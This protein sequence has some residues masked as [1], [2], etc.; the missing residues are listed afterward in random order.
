MTTLGQVIAR[1]DEIKPN[2]FTYEAKTVWLNECEGMIQTEIML[3]GVEEVI[4]YS[5]P[6]DEYTELLAAPPHDKVYWTYLAAM[7]DF[8]N[9]EYNRYQ[10]TV[11]LFNAHYGEYMRWYANRY[12]PADGVAETKGYYLSAYGIAVKHGFEGTEEEWLLTLKGESLKYEE[13]TEED[14]NDVARRLLEAGVTAPPNTLTI[15]SVTKGENASASITGQSPNQVLNLVL[16]K[17]DRGDK[18]NGIKEIQVGDYGLEDGSPYWRDLV[19]VLDD[20]TITTVPGI[21]D[22]ASAYWIAVQNGFEGTVEE[23]LESLKGEP[24]SGGGFAYEI[25]HGLKVEDNKL[26][27]DSVDNFDRDN[28][29]P[30]SAALVQTTVGNIEEI[31]KTI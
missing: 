26:M 18:G 31:L 10:N 22:G 16:P 9:G 12:R 14:K 4:E 8:A 30:A 7:I 24:G 29:L 1:V 11:Q 19:I 28:T 2:A 6:G 23:W 25:G 5:W 21:S 17:G 3:L 13:M 15:G 27:V 20:G